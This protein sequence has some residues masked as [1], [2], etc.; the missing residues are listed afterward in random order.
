[1]S[2]LAVD[3]SILISKKGIPIFTLSPSFNKTLWINPF[4]EAG[5]SIAALSV[6][7]TIIGSSLSTNCP[8]FTQTSITSTSSNSPKS[9]KFIICMSA[10][11]PPKDLVC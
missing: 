7:R 4:T 5:I 8:S 6:S 2:S 10:I 9:G 1:M 3:G 11:K